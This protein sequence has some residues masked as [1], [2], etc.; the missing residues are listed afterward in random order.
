MFINILTRGFGTIRSF[1]KRRSRSGNGAL[2]RRLHRWETRGAPMSQPPFSL[3]GVACTQF[4][5]FSVADYL[6]FYLTHFGLSVSLDRLCVCRKYMDE[7]L[8]VHNEE[9]NSVGH[10]FSC[11]CATSQPSGCPIN[12]V[13]ADLN[14]TSRQSLQSPQNGKWL[15]GSALLCFLLTL[16]LFL[17]FSYLFLFSCPQQLNR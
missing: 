17:L 7:P 13:R 8:F 11:K 1:A 9:F 6:F 5:F 16:L 3:P 4:R 14:L 12:A 15:K 10:G 2:R